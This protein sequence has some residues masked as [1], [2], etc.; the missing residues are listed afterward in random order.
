MIYQG[1]DSWVT[2]FEASTADEAEIVR[3]MMQASKIP[4]ILDRDTSGAG[5]ADG[6]DSEVMVKV[7]KEMA[8]RATQ[9]LQA[10]PYGVPEE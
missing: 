5:V 1:T 9:L 6:S 2:V 3:G 10:T 4:V 7:P 8:A